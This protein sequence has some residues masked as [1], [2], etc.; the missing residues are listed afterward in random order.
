MKNNNRKQNQV[1]RACE[2]ITGTVSEGWKLNFSL[3]N[4]SPSPELSEETHTPASSVFLA[5]MM[6]WLFLQ[7]QFCLHNAVLISLLSADQLLYKDE[8]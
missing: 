6:I 2:K 5:D 1:A 8:K 4:A 7:P 3:H